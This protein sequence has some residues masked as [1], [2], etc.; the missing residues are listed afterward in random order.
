MVAIRSG[1]SRATARVTRDTGSDARKRGRPR[2]SGAIRF[3]STMRAA[4]C[5][6]VSH[7][8]YR[9]SF[10]CAWRVNLTP[11]DARSR[12]FTS[13]AGFVPDLHQDR[14]GPITSRP[15]AT[16]EESARAE[17]RP[18]RAPGAARRPHGRPGARLARRRQ[19][20]HPLRRPPVLDLRRLPRR[21]HRHRRHPPRAGGCLRRRGLREGDP[22]AGDRRADR[23]PGRDQRDERDGRGEVQPLAAR[24]PRRPRAGDALGLG[25]APGDRPP[26]VRLAGDQVGA[27][28]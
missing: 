25:L 21:G 18:A 4:T 19:A 10:L 9:R 23:R 27:R 16:T 15:M 12:R 3:S 24:R 14:D 26:A 6:A 2:G 8:P 22:Q 17:G 13:G 5:S 1:S 20:L 28:R 11:P 7:S